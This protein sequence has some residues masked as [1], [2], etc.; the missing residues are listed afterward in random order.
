MAHGMM[1][2]GSPT[3]AL[4]MGPGMGGSAGLSGPMRSNSFS[5]GS[6]AGASNS[7]HQLGHY[8]NLGAGAGLTGVPMLPRRAHSN[9][10]GPVSNTPLSLAHPSLIPSMPMS[11]N[12]KPPPMQVQFPGA[13]IQSHGQGQVPSTTY[14]TNQARG[15]LHAGSAPPGFN[16]SGGTS[17]GGVASIVHSANAPSLAQTSSISGLGLS[18]RGMSAS[19]P[20]SSIATNISLTP[21]N[22]T[23]SLMPH[24][25]TS[26][27][28]YSSVEDWVMGMLDDAELS[29]PPPLP[30]R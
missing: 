15:G 25:P 5:H 28:Q 3:S 6:G 8:G 16:M 2:Y 18:A 4:G 11:N 14:T 1:S 27:T 9:P 21:S 29:P 24:T 30:S 13:Q 7:L 10:S 23:D 22:S 26:A 17:V 12:N 20:R 19:L